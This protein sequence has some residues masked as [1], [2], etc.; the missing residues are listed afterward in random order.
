M[1][2]LLPPD[3][4]RS[5]LRGV[6]KVL[7]NPLYD[8]Q[9]YASA[10]QTSLS[11]FS[12]PNG[13]SGKTLADTNMKLSG[14]LPVGEAATI[15]FIEVLFFPGSAVN[16]AGAIATSGLNWQDVYT[17]AKSGFLRFTIGSTDFVVDGP[18][19]MFPP[20]TRLAGSAAM[21]D[22]T[23]A[24]AALHSQIDYAA[25]AGMRYQIPPQGIESNMSFNVTLNWPVAVA[26]PSGVAGRIGVRLDGQ[27]FR[28][29]Q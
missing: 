17:V 8:Y 9:T 18:I 10:G 25:F 3:K 21:A 4:N 16:A 13:S 28:S 6:D 27:Y 20:I 15:Q 29:A 19:G 22:A 26:L 1:A 2:K 5:R 7:R 23:S 14:Q 11:F 24:A 12:T